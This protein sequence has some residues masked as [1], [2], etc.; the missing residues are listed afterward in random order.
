MLRVHFIDV[1]YGDAILL[2]YPGSAYLL[3]DAGPGTSDKKLV[4]YL[5]S[6]GIKALDSVMITHPHKNHF[7]GLKL[8][9]Q[10]IPVGQVFVNEDHNGEEGYNELLS[11]LRKKNIPIRV[12]KKDDVLDIGV[13]GMN[14]SILHPGQLSD[15]VNANSIVS[16]LTYGQTAFLFTSDIGENVQDNLLR[17]FPGIKTADCVQIPHHGGNVS[18]RFAGYFLSPLY[19]V[20]TGANPWGKPIHESLQKLKDQI[21]RTDQAGTIVIESDGQRVKVLEN[22]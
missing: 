7:G 17:D 14:L 22:K 9:V 8:L 4:E 18:D 1:G 16:W 2:D 19:I 5:L 21:L 13:P 11:F 20:S 10:K 15:D 6:L 12:L 3:I